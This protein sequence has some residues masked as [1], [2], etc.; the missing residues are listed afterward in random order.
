MGARPKPGP[1][2]SLAD[3][4]P[5]L[6]RASCRGGGQ[7][8]TSG[9]SAPRPPGEWEQSARGDACRAPRG[10][11]GNLQGSIPHNQTPSLR[12]T[13]ALKQPEHR[14]PAAPMLRTG[15]SPGRRGSSLPGGLDGVCDS[16]GAAG[17]PR[18]VA[19]VKQNYNRIHPL[20]PG[21]R[22]AV[23]YSCFLPRT[24]KGLLGASPP[25][26]AASERNQGGKEGEHCHL[27]ALH[28]PPRSR[29]QT[30]LG[31][32]LPRADV[33]M[34]AHRTPPVRSAGRL[35]ACPALGQGRSPS[36]VLGRPRHAQSHPTL[37]P[38]CLRVRRS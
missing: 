36:G 19:P 2:P 9:A 25:L 12:R 16:E 3:E 11:G 1:R 37:D 7:H 28:I 32:E 15:K 26:P 24:G 33:P 10:P 21:P 20:L 27:R 29:R 5:S 4:P 17:G 8:P 31:P 22:R 13:G 35:H 6:P 30:R 38:L 18:S 23:K 14:Q 34:E